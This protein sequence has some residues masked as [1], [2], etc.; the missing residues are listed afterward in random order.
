M[1]KAHEETE[2]VKAEAERAKAEADRAKM[3]ALET[4]ILKTF[5][6]VDIYETVC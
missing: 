6:V 3:E 4:E 1:R 2:R 5:G